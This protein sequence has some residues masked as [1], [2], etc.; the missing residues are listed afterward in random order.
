MG[1]GKNEEL[2]DILYN[3]SK[4]AAATDELISSVLEMLIKI[5]EGAQDLPATCTEIYEQSLITLIGIPKAITSQIY[6]SY[7]T[8]LNKRKEYTEV[9]KKAEEMYE[10]FTTNTIS[11]EWICKVFNQWYV[12]GNNMA[13]EYEEKAFKYCADLLKFDSRNSMGLFTK[14][15]QLI[16]ENKTIESVNLLTKGVTFA[17]FSYCC[18]YRSVFS[19]N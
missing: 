1:Q 7:I 8:I 19:D 12:E 10:K 3:V 13:E 4:K 9:L 15:I 16:K 6:S 18:Y 17:F 14:S 5:Y 2:I 11:L